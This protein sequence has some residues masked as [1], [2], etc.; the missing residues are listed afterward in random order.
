MQASFSADIHPQGVER[1]D[2]QVKYWESGD[3]FTVQIFGVCFYLSSEQYKE[4]LPM[5][6][7]GL[8]APELIA[9][10]IHN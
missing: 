6:H 9:G 8:T 1:G 5:L 4:L 2:V 10:D 3:R 7:K